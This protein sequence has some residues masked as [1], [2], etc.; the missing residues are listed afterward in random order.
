MKWSYGITTVLPRR[1]ELLPRTLRSLLLAGFDRPILFIDGADGCSMAE[2]ED[3]FGLPCSVRSQRIRTH[4]NWVLALL[5]LFIREPYADRYAIFQDDL[6]TYRNLRQ[7]LEKCEYPYMGYLNLYT[8]P[9]NQKL[10]PDYCAGRY[11]PCWYLSNQLGRGAVALV[12]NSESARHLLCSRDMLERPMD[13][14][15]G[16]RA[17]DG[18]V[19]HSL[20]KVGIKE[21]VHTPSL[22]QHIGKHSS[23][24]NKPHLLAISFLGE[25]F[26]AL[27]L[28]R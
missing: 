4:G 18:G 17:V 12:F 11:R 9:S 21:Y 2:Y 28:L 13:A 6:V 24:G 15:R 5:E 26:D 3:T 22:T 23:M 8:F 10:A 7:Y 20:A 1:N 14:H 16:H 27:D 25:E 19:V